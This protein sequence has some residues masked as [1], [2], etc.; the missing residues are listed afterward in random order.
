MCCVVCAHACAGI[1]LSTLCVSQNTPSQSMTICHAWILQALFQHYDISNSVCTVRRCSWGN[2]IVFCQIRLVDRLTT[3][4]SLVLLISDP[5]ADLVN[6][7]PERLEKKFLVRGTFFVHALPHAHGHVYIIRMH[8]PQCPD[9][10]QGSIDS[11]DFKGLM[12]VRS[13][14]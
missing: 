9:T 14:V 4:R 1:L 5:I 8:V 3:D 13:L 11:S 2:A 10:P 12:T 7:F 6:P